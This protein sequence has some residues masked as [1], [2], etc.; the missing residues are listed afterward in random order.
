MAASPYANP[1]GSL[2]KVDVKGPSADEQQKAKDAGGAA[3]LMRLLAGAAPVA[4]TAIGALVGGLAG[5]VPTAGA[6]AFPGAAA[7]AS[8]GGG[9]GKLAGNALEG[10]AD[11]ATRE[12]EEK[13][14]AR[15]RKLEALQRVAG[16][17]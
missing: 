5:G 3:D 1:Y 15:R 10:G 4:G 13:D 14:I 9:L 12:S 6:G 2:T 11:A 8:I 17:L 16:L 7:G